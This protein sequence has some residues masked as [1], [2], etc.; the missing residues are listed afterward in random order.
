MNWKSKM[1]VVFAASVLGFLVSR[2][3]RSTQG[4]MSAQET[5][6]DKEEIV[7]DLKNNSVKSIADIESEIKVIRSKITLPKDKAVFKVKSENESDEILKTAIIASHHADQLG[8]LEELFSESLV[9]LQKSPDESLKSIRRMLSGIPVKDFYFDRASLI[10][11]AS[12]LSNRADHVD[13]VKEMAW[14]E[15]KLLNV[16]NPKV[17]RSTVPTKQDIIEMNESSRQAIL[18]LTSARIL[19]ELSAGGSASIDDLIKAIQTQ[20]HLGIRSSMVAI[21]KNKFPA[22]SKLIDEEI[23][24]RMIDLE[25]K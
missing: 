21:Y 14:Q 18:P 20:E 3:N 23:A 12:K 24:K 17:S 9:K 2:S 6:V 22:D 16:K 5:V 7:D 19:I 25:V 15:L 10:A 11:T 1:I 8:N 4:N 13:K